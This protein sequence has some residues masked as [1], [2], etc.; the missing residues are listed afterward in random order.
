M[1][2]QK[3]KDIF[4]NATYPMKIPPYQRA[5]AWK[6]DEVSDFVNDMKRLFFARKKDNR[7]DTHFMGG[8]VAY[9]ENSDIIPQKTY[10]IIDGQQRLIT[11]S[12]LLSI[13]KHEY[14]KLIEKFKLDENSDYLERT[15][16]KLFEVERVFSHNETDH[17]GKNHTIPTLTA[18]GS[19]E[20]FFKQVIERNETLNPTKE[21]HTL[22]ARAKRKI[23]RD[24][25]NTI[26][27]ECDNEEAFLNLSL[28]LESIKE[29]CV[30]IFI[31]CPNQSDAYELFQ[32][33]N[34]RGKSLTDGDL[35]RAYTF[36]RA[37]DFYADESQNKQLTDSWNEMLGNPDSKV[38]H[39][40]EQY[41]RIQTGEA[42]EKR[43]L[44]RQFQEKIFAQQRSIPEL[45]SYVE[46]MRDYFQ[47]FLDIINGDWPFEND[48]SSIE[49]YDK[50][51]LK[52][53]TTIL[54]LKNISILMVAAIKNDQ[55]L[56]RDIMYLIEKFFFR[57]RTICEGSAS[58]IGN[59][60][61]KFAYK[62]KHDEFTLDNFQ[63]EMRALVN[64]DTPDTI[65]GEELKRKLVYEEKSSAKQRIRF[66]LFYIE[67]HKSF[68]DNSPTK[69]REK[70]TI[71]PIKKSNTI[72]HIYPQNPEC[73][74]PDTNITQHP[75][76]G[77]LTNTMG[78][79]TVIGPND[80]SSLGNKLFDKKQP[81]YSRSNIWLNREIAQQTTWSAEQI[82]EREN[83]LVERG[84]ALFS[85]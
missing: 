14:K 5:Y 19:D 11:I 58:K 28:L 56:F 18:S 62:L 66:F 63:E 82:L 85:I 26:N 34:D 13:I 6:T 49:V 44:Y 32:V 80:N 23:E 76:R 8:I 2:V 39:F 79:L 47:K 68:F 43:Q 24:L 69:K 50:E 12:I 45:L 38:K 59:F 51:C 78:N 73:G 29:D 40:L 30:I 16:N 46:D 84:I 64:E 60:L 25:V 4:F 21:S 70:S 31:V 74:S 7:P 36:Q 9:E 53:L 37:H 57:Y 10:Y 55:K 48:D 27:K 65:F 67:D 3:I 42:P 1:Q 77:D 41:F 81:V 33:L 22:I 72:E 35:L 52:T 54:N 20:D 75:S 83:R 71:H 61:G 15:N 17:L